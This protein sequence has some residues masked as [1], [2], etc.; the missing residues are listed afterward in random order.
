MSKV[1]EFY[2]VNEVQKPQQNRVYHDNDAC[3]PGRDI[4]QGERRPGRNGYRLCND[5]DSLDKQGK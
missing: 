3:P 1:S 5:C 2:S 4:P